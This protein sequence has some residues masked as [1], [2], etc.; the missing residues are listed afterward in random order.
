MI[1]VLLEL[2]TSQ[3][4]NNKGFITISICTFSELKRSFLVITPLC[5][6]LKRFRCQTRVVY[7]YFIYIFIIIKKKLIIIIVIII[8]IWDLSSYAF[9]L[10]FI[11]SLPQFI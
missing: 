5:N 11:S 9:R 7:F 10:D 4:P 3:Q 1:K 6:E 8:D 2:H